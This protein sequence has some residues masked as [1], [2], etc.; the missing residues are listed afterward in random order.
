[1]TNI[2]ANY[3]NII[4]FS[5]YKAAAIEVA[6]VEKRFPIIYALHNAGGEPLILFRF[7]KDEEETKP[8]YNNNVL[9]FNSN[10]KS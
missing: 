10:R 4:D 9:Q 7:I 3:E 1:M 8:H 2:L 6:E 5:K